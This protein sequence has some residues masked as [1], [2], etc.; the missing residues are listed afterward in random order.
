MTTSVSGG[1]AAEFSRGSC[2]ASLLLDALGAVII[3]ADRSADV[4]YVN[5]TGEALLGI[6]ER[7]P[8]GRSLWELLPGDEEQ[9]LPLK[10]ACERVWKEQCPSLQQKCW[11]PVAG[12]RRDFLWTIRFL[13][14]DERGGACLLITG[15]DIT[16]EK[17]AGD[18]VYPQA[19]IFENIFD[20][21][22]LADARGN[23]VDWNPAAERLFGYAREEV[24]G[25]SSS[26]FH[27]PTD[28]PGL[29]QRILDSLQRQGRWVGEM[30]FVRKDG[31]RGVLEA[32]IT[33]LCA[34]GNVVASVG[35][36]RDI[37][38]RKRIENDLRRREAI[39]GA[40]SF[41]AECFL[42]GI[43]WEAE[44]QAALERL[45]QAAD[46]SRVYIFQNHLATAGEL[47]TSQRYEWVAPGVSAQINNPRYQNLSYNQETFSGRQAPLAANQIVYGP[48]S[49]F[50]S[51][52]QDFLA[53]EE[54]RSLLI[55]PIFV[56]QQWWGFI[57]FDE[58]R[59]ERLWGSGEIESLRA[60]AGIL[61]AAIRRT[62]LEKIH[63][64][65]L[66]ISETAHSAKS[67]DEVYYSIHQTVSELMP[68][69]NL[70]IALYD[71]DTDMLSFPYF[72]DQFDVPPAT[73]KPGKTLT[74]YLLRTGKPL[75]VT[76]QIY[77]ELVASGDVEGAGAY[78]IDWMG[79]PLKTD[80]VV[81]GALVVQSYSEGVRFNPEDVE[82]LSYV[83]TQIAMAIER[84]RA[85]DAVHR[86][87]Q[88]LA[89]LRTVD[90]AISASLDMRVSLTVLLDHV[91]GQLNVDAA[92]VLILSPVTR[93]LEYM[94]GWG[95]RTP[96]FSHASV[97]LSDEF[98]GRAVVERRKIGIENITPAVANSLSQRGLGHENFVAYY[99]IP[100]IAKSQV[101]GVLE[102]FHRTP[103]QM[104]R[105]WHDFLDTLAGQAAIAIENA[106]LFDELQHSNADLALAYDSTLEGWVRALDMRAPEMEGHTQRVT[107]L[108]LTLARA[109]GVPENDLVH[110]RRGALLHDIGKIA[111]PD[112]V[113]QNVGPL[114][115]AEEAVMNCHPE[116]AYELLH[117]ID[118]LRYALDI[119]YCHHERWDGTGYPRRLKGEQ[120]PLSA[121]IFA[122]VDAWDSLS[123]GRHNPPPWPLERV[124]KHIQ[125][126]AGRAFDPHVVQVFLRLME[127][128][129]F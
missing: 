81:F 42:R 6:K 121:R 60:A 32:V 20:A 104:D 87:M 69:H 127:T 90:M 33:T 64:A 1:E 82:M 18:E 103:L 44:I 21:V 19:L 107:N 78:S 79:V 117:P 10:A 123:T 109:M 47:L 105:D 83:S 16:A 129:S 8:E 98:A 74:G 56:E 57:G 77:Q 34:G 119:P 128:S 110:V 2:Q 102:V 97:P 70:Y 88:R 4:L 95:F 92:D 125:S 3:L 37:T 43:S 40:V 114:T 100:L 25:Q 54:T 62:R 91:T 124:I 41:A 101:K 71:R 30:N 63:A 35:V 48:L 118:Y 93:R 26:L 11:I 14:D 55:V 85:E 96:S 46:V 113:L 68:A 9:T 36:N 17:S 22:V 116:L 53:A 59:Y 7:L 5:R 38:E 50:S 12:E 65:T 73:G 45:G 31:S 58:C 76:P 15:V 72:V 51:A 111:I 84:R 112:G 106:S 94:A 27:C 115:E 23:I 122:V 49:Q 86:R 120:I 126:E 61:G 89:A 28:R 66:H 108:T 80:S 39:L 67:M 13:A 29:Q 24:V 52:A 99:A 75:L